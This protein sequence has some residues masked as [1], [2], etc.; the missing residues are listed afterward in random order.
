[1]KFNQLP[2][3]INWS[4]SE[5]LINEKMS[6]SLDEFKEMINEVNPSQINLRLVSIQGD[7]YYF[8]G[9]WIR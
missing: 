1:M 7:E 9:F 8:E 5:V 4:L 3:A 6:G 2:T